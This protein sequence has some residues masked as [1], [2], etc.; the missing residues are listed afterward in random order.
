MSIIT[1]KESNSS[2]EEDIEIDAGMPEKQSKT[3]F[4]IRLFFVLLTVITFLLS[5]RILTDG[6]VLIGKDIAEDA[7]Y[8]ISNPF[9]GFFIGLLAT[10]MI[11]SSSTTT[12][13]TVTLVGAGT[14][15]FSAAV[16]VIMGANIGTTVTSSIV[17]FS[18]ITS[19]KEFR[20]AIAASV[21]HDIFNILTAAILLP[22]E[23][24]TGFLSD[25]GQGLS[26]HIT[27]MWQGIDISGDFLKK[28]VDSIAQLIIPVFNHNGWVLI[29]VSFLL[30]FWSL[31]IFNKTTKS[32]LLGNSGKRV[33]D[34]VFSSQR[35]SFF[36]G[37]GITALIQSSSVTTSFIVP[38]V[39]I[40]RVTVKSAF[41]FVVGANIGTTVTALIAAFSK[42][43]AALSIAL[44]H[45][46][47]NL[48]GMLLL[49]PI[50][51]VRGRVVQLAKKI[52]KLTL[53]NRAYGFVYILTV[54]FFIPF[55]L[56]Y[57]FSL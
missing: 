2:S 54:F 44:I 6:F 41:P 3:L 45:M 34:V 11:Q 18:H 19:R 1:V 32:F 8:A 42:S 20:K 48:L 33:N 15:S 24:F 36:W 4:V 25:L 7:L 16:P 40:G 23:Y 27:A 38:L 10:A 50:P 35:R 9:V 30:L 13:L 28:I 21:L 53:K 55:L 52:G 39:A 26:S 57:L 5:L 47:F 56:I 49:L 17:A 51:Y 12:A 46:L 31:K 43:E 37:F 22:L 29:A 14:L